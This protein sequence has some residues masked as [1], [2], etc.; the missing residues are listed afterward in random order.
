[1][2]IDQV[3][4]FK[5]LSL[6]KN[7]VN[8]YISITLTGLYLSPK[9]KS[10]F[11][12]SKNHN[13]LIYSNTPIYRRFWGKKKAKGF[14]INRGFDCLHYVYIKPCLVK[15]N[16]CGKLGYYC[17]CL[18]VNEKML[19]P[20][21]KHVMSVLLSYR[22]TINSFLKCEGSTSTTDLN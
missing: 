3:V 14:A 7:E 6:W 5:L 4:E 21:W 8:L 10:V 19:G 13:M 22:V 18:T 15:G 20:K 9:H 1:M 11:S 16:S 17:T 12:W 2:V